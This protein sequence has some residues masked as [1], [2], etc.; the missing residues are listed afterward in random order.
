MIWGMILMFLMI[1]L[2]EGVVAMCIWSRL[3]E[4]LTG[5]KEA[6]AALTTHLFCPLLGRKNDGQAP[7]SNRSSD[8]RRSE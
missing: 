2:I 8:P 6:V 5:N 3:A 1:S 4:H 7:D